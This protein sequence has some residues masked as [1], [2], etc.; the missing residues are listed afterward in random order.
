[1]AQDRATS[2]IYGMP[3][4]AADSGFVDQVLPL[5]DI[6]PAILR[7]MEKDRTG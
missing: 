4:S 7:L 6:A 3:R 1:L 5:E 2:V